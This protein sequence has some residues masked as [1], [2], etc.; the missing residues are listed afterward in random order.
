MPSQGLEGVVAAQTSLS[1]VMGEEGRLIYAG[2]EI[3]DLAEKTSF[4]EV[5]HLLWHGELP[6][7]GQLDAMRRELGEA[8]TLAP[9]VIEILR[10]IP[11]DAHPM[12]ALRTALS[13]AGNFDPDAEDDSE[14]ANRR[15]AVRITGQIPSISAAFERLRAGEPIVE[16]DPDRPLAEDFLRML[17]GKEP[18]ELEARIMDVALILH[19][20]HGLNA[21]TFSARVTIATLSDMYS[22]IVSA[23]GTLK[24]PLHGGANQEVMRMLQEIGDPAAAGDHVR[25]A[26][27]RKERIMGF[28]HR[29][30][31]ALDPR[32]PILKALAEDL[33]RERGESRWLEI[34]D[35]VNRTMREEMDA[36]GKKI[37]ANVDFYSAAVYYT[38]GIPIDQFTNIFAISRATGWTANVLEQLSDNR[39]IRPKAEYVGPLDKTVR[40]LDERS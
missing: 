16:A 21:S 11:H 39:L 22:A 24:G 12:A 28:G 40:P 20:D 38:L 1:K 34:A 31:R 13:A 30:Y 8:R 19:A 17:T 36:R 25:A 18:G 33:G 26:L 10:L 7:R 15:K 27:E 3:D 32:A 9:G 6:D 23:V 35:A 5:C 2:Y 37:Y 29:V 14:A 4:E